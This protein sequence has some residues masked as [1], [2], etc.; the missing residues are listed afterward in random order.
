MLRFSSLSQ[1]GNSYFIIYIQIFRGMMYMYS[2]LESWKSNS[3][4]QYGSHL[5]CGTPLVFNRLLPLVTP[6]L[7]QK[8]WI[9]HSSRSSVIVRKQKVYARPG[10]HPGWKHNAPDLNFGG[11]GNK[12]NKRPKGLVL[13]WHSLYW[14]GIISNLTQMNVDLCD[15]EK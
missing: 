4:F 5:G 14:S 11:R 15:L 6:H 9:S 1:T 7:P 3:T 8:I 13:S 12:N 10:G 2:H